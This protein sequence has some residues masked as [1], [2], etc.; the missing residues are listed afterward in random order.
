MANKKTSAKA[1]P[2]NDTNDEAQPNLLEPTEEPNDGQPTQTEETD[3]DRPLPP[4]EPAPVDDS[5]D[6]IDKEDKKELGTAYGEEPSEAELGEISDTL[7]NEP[8]DKTLPAN[9]PQ[10]LGTREERPFHQPHEIKYAPPV[11]QREFDLHDPPNL[12]EA[13]PLLPITYNQKATLYTD[14]HSHAAGHN[15]ERAYESPEYLQT[16]DPEKREAGDSSLSEAALEARTKEDDQKAEAVITRDD[17]PSQV[18]RN[19]DE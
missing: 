16:N 19:T 2:K 6:T 8:V 14:E 17:D 13:T 5:K 4:E 1:Q 10:E 3:K 15:V 12:L 11:G 18:T 7:M 9:P